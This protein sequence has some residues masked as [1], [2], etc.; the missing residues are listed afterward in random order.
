MRRRKYTTPYK[1]KAIALS[2]EKNNV[3]AAARELGIGAPMIHRWKKEKKEY[4]HNSFPGHGSAKMTDQERK[5]ARLEK[6]LKDAQLETEILKK[7]ISIFSKS[8]RK[9]LGS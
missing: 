9:N 3:A 7:A 2:E 1:E 8:D 4:A 5:I 6:A